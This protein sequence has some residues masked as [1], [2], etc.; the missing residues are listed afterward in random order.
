MKIAIEFDGVIVHRKP[1]YTDTTT[2]FTPVPGA[3]TALRSLWAARHS[4]I[5]WSARL[6]P[7]LTEDWRLNPTWAMRAREGEFDV[8]RWEAQRELHLARRDEMLMFVEAELHGVFAMVSG[9]YPH[10]DM[11]VTPK[12]PGPRPNL[13]DIAELYGEHYEQT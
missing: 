7:T 5:L 6:D 2:P 4:L 13:I 12:I 3:L 9:G 8:A 10:C 11:L 1:D